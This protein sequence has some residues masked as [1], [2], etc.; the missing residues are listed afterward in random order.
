MNHA[1]DRVPHGGQGRSQS[2]WGWAWPANRRI[3]YNRASADPDGKPWSERKKYVWW[4]E[5]QRRWVGDDVPD[6]VVDRA[7]GSR[8]DP[9]LGGPAALAGDDAFIMQS[10]GKALAVRPQGHG[11]RPAPDA[12]RAAGVPGRQRALPA[13]AEPDPGHLP[14]GRTT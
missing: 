12:L 8:P 2:E 13:A 3:L 7:P 10:D 1:A 11:R 14:R 9:D 5:E 4:D 6:F